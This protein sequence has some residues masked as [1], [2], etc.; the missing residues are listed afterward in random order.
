LSETS[1]VESNTYAAT[2]GIEYVLNDRWAAGIGWSHVWSDNTLQNDLG[3]FDI[4]GDSVST[5]LSYF[6]NNFWGDLLYSFGHY[7][8]DIHRNTF[9]G[10][11]VGA[12]PELN[13][14]QTTL[15]L[16]YN[17]PVRN[18]FVHGPTFRA[19]YN[20]G[21][22]DGYTETGDDR[23]NTIFDDQHYETLV[24]TLGWQIN[25]ETETTFRA[26][27][28]PHFRV[29]YGRENI[30][31]ESNVNGTLAQSPYQ[32][33]NL[34]TGEVVSRG[35]LESRSLQQV[36]PGEGWMEFGAGLGMEFNNGFGLFFDYQGRA[37][38]DDA[39]LHLGTVKARLRW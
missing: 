34:S 4:D 30:D 32:R 36:D 17:I 11:T 5:Y 16:G 38:Q 26:K 27:L 6:N 21:R 37:F 14:H 33:I 7:Q 2:A 8:V 29:A 10:S 25:W 22:L 39:H 3:G 24:T 31:Q 35:A 20:S 9:L 13:S 23:A 18:Q 28:S 15:N 19:N 1:G 12:T